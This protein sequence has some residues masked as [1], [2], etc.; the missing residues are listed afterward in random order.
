MGAGLLAAIAGLA[1]PM[2]A[3]VLL[4]IGFSVVT[5]GGVQ[6]AVS[7]LKGQLMSYLGAAP[8]AGLQ[9]AGLAGVWEGLGMVLGAVSFTVSLWGLTKAVRIVKG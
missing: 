7:G 5:L 8:S 1:G 3:R 6:A 9:L 4:A 2:F